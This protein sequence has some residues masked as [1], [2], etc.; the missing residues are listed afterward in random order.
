[1]NQ[2]VKLKKRSLFAQKNIHTI[3]MNCLEL[4]KKEIRPQKGLNLDEIQQYKALVY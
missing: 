3:F 1:M 2:N 4:L